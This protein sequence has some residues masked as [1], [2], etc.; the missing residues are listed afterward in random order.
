MIASH[1]GSASRRS[2]WR[3]RHCL[4]V[5]LPDMLHAREAPGG[6]LHVASKAASR[7]RAAEVLHPKW[8]RGMPGPPNGRHHTLPVHSRTPGNKSKRPSCLTASHNVDQARSPAPT[9]CR[10]TGL[11]LTVHEERP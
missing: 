4:R 10:T 6:L 9:E 5:D 7:R 1:A 11:L 8:V 3:C 2:A